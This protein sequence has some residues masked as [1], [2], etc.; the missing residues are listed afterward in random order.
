M[1]K[2]IGLF[3]FIRSI[4]EKLQFGNSFFLCFQET[5]NFG[6]SIKKRTVF[7]LT[8][9]NLESDGANLLNNLW[10]LLILIIIRW[11]GQAYSS[12]NP[13]SNHGKNIPIH[14]QIVAYRNRIG[15]VDSANL[16]KCRGT[17]GPGCGVWQGF[18]G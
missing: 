15:A 11:D 1:I 2:I 3:L 9:P 4:R 7:F 16:H 8:L 14:W 13:I 10:F 17:L 18:N 12:T 5:F 6:T